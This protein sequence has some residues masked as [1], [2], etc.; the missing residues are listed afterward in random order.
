MADISVLVPCY[1]E[2]EE[3]K[4][5]ILALDSALKKLDRSYEIIVVDDSSTDATP[6]ILKQM[7]NKH[8]RVARYNTGPSRRENLGRELRKVRG[9][10]VVFMDA[11]LATDLRHL[12]QLIK[13]LD[14]GAD[15][16]IGSRYDKGAKIIRNPIRRTY[17]FLYNKTIQFLF[18]STIRDHQCGFK[19]FTNPAIQTLTA[20]LGKDETL[21]RGWFWDAELLI[22]AQRQGMNIAVIP[23]HWNRGA[24][25]SFSLKRELR[26][27]PYLLGL[28]VRLWFKK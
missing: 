12:P 21:M 6:Q 5:N 24:K 13:E 25:S 7:E 10:Y 20:A 19:A 8:I 17:S 1:N 11:D 22:R 2:E 27:I 16:S 14:A 28:R 18:G 3:I 15:I 9:K 26:V 4:K 23:V